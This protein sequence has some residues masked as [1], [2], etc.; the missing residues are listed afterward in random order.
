MEYRSFVVFFRR[1]CVEKMTYKKDE[2][3]QGDSFDC[4]DNYLSFR[5]NQDVDK[6]G[7]GDDGKFNNANSIKDE[8]F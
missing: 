1:K 7:G 6:E 5:M 3:S 2:L 4:Q 8:W